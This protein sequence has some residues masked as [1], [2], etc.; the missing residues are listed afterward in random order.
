[1]GVLLLLTVY[2]NDSY[3]GFAEYYVKVVASYGTLRSPI[4]SCFGSDS[5]LAPAHT[6]IISDLPLCTREAD[7]G[8]RLI[9][10]FGIPY[11]RKEFILV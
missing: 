8:L 4:V 7:G 11:L 1:M 2:I 3:L 9:S 10:L 6:I 5:Y